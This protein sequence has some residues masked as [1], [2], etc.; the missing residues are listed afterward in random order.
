[1]PAYTFKAKLFY[2]YCHKDIGLREYMED[3]LTVISPTP[4]PV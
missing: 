3:S 1:M 2:S 4:T